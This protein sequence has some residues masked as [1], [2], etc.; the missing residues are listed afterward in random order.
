MGMAMKRNKEH[1][2]GGSPKPTSQRA[3]PARITAEQEKLREWNRLMRLA[4]YQA[5]LA[6]LHKAEPNLEKKF[7]QAINALHDCKALEEWF[8]KNTPY[9][10]KIEHRYHIPLIASCACGYLKKMALSDNQDA[11]KTLARLSVDMTETLTEFLIGKSEAAKSN[12]KL[13]QDLARKAEGLW[14]KQTAEAWRK[15][16]TPSN[17]EL[18][19]SIA[20]ELP[21]WPMLRFCNTAANSKKQFQRIA[22]QL[23]LGKECPINVAASANYSLETPINAFVWKCLRHF[24]DVHSTIRL[25]LNRPGPAKALE[26][27]IEPIV[28]QKVESP[29]ARRAFIC[30]MINGADVPIYKASYSLPPLTTATAKIWADKAIVLPF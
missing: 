10:F 22:H 28:F 9:P 19:R 6:E 11:I 1:K 5:K 23:E 16:Q 13:I 17:A 14:D 25:E 2:L 3:K 12:E 4:E 15:Q 8:A 27:A 29:P 20:C 18:L 30:G 26:E 24:Q 21:Y 7:H